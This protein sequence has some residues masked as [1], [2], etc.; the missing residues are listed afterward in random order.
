[1]AEN[2]ARPKGANYYKYLIKN[3]MWLYVRTADKKAL[4]RAKENYDKY[5]AF[6]G[7]IS[8]DTFRHQAFK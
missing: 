7:K 2:K 6:G 3:D 1:M 5:V 4:E 8:F